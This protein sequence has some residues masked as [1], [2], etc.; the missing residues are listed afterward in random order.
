[1]LSI[2][3]CDD[4]KLF[5]EQLIKTLEDICNRKDI[6][7][8]LSYFYCGDD[9]LEKFYNF[10]LI[11]LDIIMPGENGI[12]IAERIN[13]LRNGS[14]IPYVVFVTSKDNLVFAALKQ[15]PF[16]FVRKGCLGNDIESC[17]ERVNNAVLSI[18]NAQRYPVKVG[19]DVIFLESD[20]IL[21]IQKESNYSIFVTDNGTYKERSKIGDKYTDLKQCN[22]IRTN[23]GCLV[24][25]ARIIEL[26]TDE[27][28]LDNKDVISVSKKYRK[29][30]KDAYLKYLSR[31][32]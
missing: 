1:M 14:E 32:L 6:K 30:V 31:E 2:A 4:D 10:D 21:Y 25:T 27:V 9:L 26:R 5:A 3:V 24:N 7:Y 11:F 22:F 28:V 19:R 8:S 18:S 13:K 29:D 17:L 23:V 20:K 15:F 12:K 16:S